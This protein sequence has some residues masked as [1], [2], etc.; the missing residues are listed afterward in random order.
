LDFAQA[1]E[2][3]SLTALP[4]FMLRA[5]EILLPGGQQLSHQLASHTHEK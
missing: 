5:Q 2:R 1:A 3:I 4:T